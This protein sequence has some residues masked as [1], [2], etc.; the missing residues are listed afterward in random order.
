MPFPHIPYPTPSYPLSYTLIPVILHPHTPYSTPSYPLSYTL[1][2]HILHPHTPYPTPSYPLSYTLIPLI[3]HPHNPPLISHSPSRPCN[4]FQENPLLLLCISHPPSRPLVTPPPQIN[5]YLLSRITLGLAKMLVR[6]GYLPE[7]TFDLFPWF[8][9][10]VWGVV[11]CLYEY[12]KRSL[13]PSLQSSMTYLYHDS[14]VWGGV[15]D[16]L[17]YNSAR[18]W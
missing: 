10:L 6:R 16:F 12:E 4:V 9:A 11:L 5:L 13:Q 1:I 14:T 8:G 3:L 7:P 2:P 15:W 18:L 17:A